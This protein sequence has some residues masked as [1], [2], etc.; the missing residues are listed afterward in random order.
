MVAALHR[1]KDD[2]IPITSAKYLST[3]TEDQTRHIFRSE[4]EVG[5]YF[6][7]TMDFPFINSKNAC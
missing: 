5:S 4:T 6:P 3:I 7:E 2:N 1:A